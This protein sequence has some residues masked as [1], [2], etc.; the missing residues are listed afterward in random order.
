MQSFGEERQG[1]MQKLDELT[2]DVQI[3]EQT[4]F[5]SQQKVDSLKA[6]LKRY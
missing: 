4:L 3:K 1:L 5:A 6:T 2:K